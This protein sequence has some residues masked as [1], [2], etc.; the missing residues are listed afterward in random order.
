DVTR[1]ANSYQAG[2]ARHR[3]RMSERR[4]GSRR[5]MTEAIFTDAITAGEHVARHPGPEPIDPLSPTPD[6]PDPMQPDP[7]G[8]DPIRPDPVPAPPPGPPGPDPEPPL[9][10]P[11]PGPAI[12]QTRADDASPELLADPDAVADA[13]PWADGWKRP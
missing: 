3:R 5:G 7:V 4:Q 6:P 2:P 9:P 12:A 8:P 1:P 11:T 13:A 10:G